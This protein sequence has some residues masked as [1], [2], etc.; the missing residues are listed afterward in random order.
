MDGDAEVIT[1]GGEPVNIPEGSWISTSRLFWVLVTAV[2]TFAA[3]KFSTK[4]SVKSGKVKGRGPKQP[5]R[6][7]KGTEDI[8]ASVYSSARFQ[9]ARMRRTSVLVK[10]LGITDQN[11]DFEKI[12]DKFQTIEEVSNAVKNAGVDSS[13]LI[14]G[15]DFTKSNLYSGRFTFD[16]HSLHYLD[17]NNLNPYQRV[18]SILGKTLAPFDK[19]GLI[20]AFGFGDSVT[21]DKRVFPFKEDES[22]CNGFE[23]V[24]S[25]YNQV[26]PKVDLGG[27][28]DFAP[29]IREAIRIVEKSGEYHILVIIGDGQVTAER[30]TQDAI[31]EAS[32]YPLSIIMVG[33][34]DGPW[35]IMEEFDDKLPKRKFDNFQFVHYEST[36]VNAEFPEAVFALNALME[37]PDQ[38]KQIKLQGLLGRK[39]EE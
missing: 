27:P 38:F 7:R 15:I 26:V 32:H 21:E 4:S 14:F 24:L 11:R 39:V 20:P 30:R 34:G 2:F 33:V 17:E 29:L 12:A 8:L 13:N 1:P 9:A 16:G 28:T 23:E 3:Y 36:V 6:A 25:I 22:Y 35:G 37:I 10:T 19:D 18:I 5:A 31:V